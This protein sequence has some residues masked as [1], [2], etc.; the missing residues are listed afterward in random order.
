MPYADPARQRAYQ[1]VYQRSK[2]YR[3]H[4]WAYHQRYKRSKKY[5]AYRRSEKYRA[6][7]CALLYLNRLRCCHAITQRT[8]VSAQAVRE[9]GYA[10]RLLAES[11]RRL[12]AINALARQTVD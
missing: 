1:Q 10:L 11:K 6:Y 8:P 5:R 9:L 7:H 12:H 4:R 3:A 2:K